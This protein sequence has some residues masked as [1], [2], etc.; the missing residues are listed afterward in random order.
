[1]STR[2]G[3]KAERR[4]RAHPRAPSCARRWARPTITPGATRSPIFW[5]FMLD[6]CLTV[7]QLA[8]ALLLCSS[9]S[10]SARPRTVNV[11]LATPWK[12]HHPV[13]DIL[14]VQV[15]TRDESDLM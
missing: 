13:F 3:R 11:S 1:M 14:C 8:T 15:S 5:F 9:A 2:V 7:G 6:L 4:A 12:A 10:A